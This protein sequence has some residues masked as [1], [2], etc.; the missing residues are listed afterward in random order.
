MKRSPLGVIQGRLLPKYQGR[1]QCHPVGYW[2]D[3]FKIVA[4]LD[5]D[6]IQL[7]LNSDTIELNPLSSSAGLEKINALVDSSGVKVSSICADYF[8][9]KPLHKISGEDLLK[10][11]EV[12]KSLVKSSKKIGSKSIVLPCLD[13]S[14]FSNLNEMKKFQELISDVIPI[15][16]DLNINLALETDLDSKTFSTFLDA[17]DSPNLT[18]NYDIGNSASFGHAIKEDFSAYG[19][20]ISDVHIKDRPLGQKSIQLGDGD[21]NFEDFFKLIDNSYYSGPFIMET[22][23]DEE[24]V[25]VFKQQLSWLRERGYV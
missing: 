18:V 13:N 4:S 9:E 16:E 10:S 1:Y 19:E 15:A 23:R 14:S 6:C 11:I 21:A 2:P 5:L 20:K 7:I 12:L 22:Y 25:K 3:E 24:G 17:I 8:M